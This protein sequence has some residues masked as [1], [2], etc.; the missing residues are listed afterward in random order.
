MVI[1]K[2]YVTIDIKFYWT[3]K[4]GHKVEKKREREK[5]DDV[6]LSIRDNRI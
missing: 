5:M 4:R 3:G 2:G 1:S 6:V